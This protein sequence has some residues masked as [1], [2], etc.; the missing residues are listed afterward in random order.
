[1]IDGVDCPP[2]ASP[3]NTEKIEQ[4]A[5]WVN[6]S[7]CETMVSESLLLLNFYIL[8]LLGNT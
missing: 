3:T 5:E 1:M 4:T 2:Q 6:R 8:N 7:A